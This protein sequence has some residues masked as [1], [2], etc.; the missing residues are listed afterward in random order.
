MGSILTKIIIFFI[1]KNFTLL[2]Y[3]DSFLIKEATQN[4]QIRLK[5]KTNITQKKKQNRFL[6]LFDFVICLQLLMFLSDL[7]SQVTSD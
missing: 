6:A 1:V 2:T 7:T 4:F 5:Q 3:F